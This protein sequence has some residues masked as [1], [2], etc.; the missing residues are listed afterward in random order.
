MTILDPYA[1]LAWLKG[2]P[3]AADVERLVRSEAGA[4]LT[5]VGVGEVLDQL[6]RNVGVPE[7][8]AAL[9]VAQLDLGEPV[10]VGAILGMLAGLL[11][12][13]HYHR[14]SRAVSL[15]D[16]VAAAAARA[17]GDGVASADPH[18]L[19]L[20]HDEGIAVHPLPDSAG[21]VWRRGGR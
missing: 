16:C 3:A 6:I 1:V 10:A 2:E 20:C 17:R 21:R 13:R 8:E 14:R 15:A 12:A 18:L 5:A 19:D 9:D 4:R 7:E 11:R